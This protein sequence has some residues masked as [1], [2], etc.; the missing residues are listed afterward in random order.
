MKKDEIQQK[1]SS[2]YPRPFYIPCDEQIKSIIKEVGED[3]TIIDVGAGSGYFMYSLLKNGH[4]RSLGIEMF[5]NTM[6]LA[7]NGLPLELVSK[8][9]PWDIADD[10]SYRMIKSLSEKSK[11]V[12]FLVRPC[13]HPLLIDTTINLAKELGIDMYY[14]GLQKNMFVDLD[15][16]EFQQIKLDGYSI[17]GEV[18]LKL[19][20]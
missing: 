9:L 12:L 18:M 16:S 7:E 4:N 8:I 1:L 10:S 19:A 6:E 5:H 15:I 13:H 3:T 17:D 20:S 11:V 2:G 14:I